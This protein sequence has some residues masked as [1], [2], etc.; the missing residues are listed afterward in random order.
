VMSM[1][2]NVVSDK[3]FEF[4]LNTKTEDLII[5]ISTPINFSKIN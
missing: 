4:P 3:I 5:N 1:T 2:K